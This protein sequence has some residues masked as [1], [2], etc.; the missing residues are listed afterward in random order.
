MPT[1]IKP[2]TTKCVDEQYVS[3]NAAGRFMISAAI[4]Q[5][6]EH[7]CFNYKGHS[8]YGIVGAHK[9]NGKYKLKVVVPS[10]S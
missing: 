4:T 6:N 1:K 7:I 2:I 10:V 9:V 3:L 8:A 5:P